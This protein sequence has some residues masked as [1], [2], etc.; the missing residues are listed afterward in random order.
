M[1]V[2]PA[3]KSVGA[4]GIGCGSQRRRFGVALVSNGPANQVPEAIGAQAAW[5]ALG[6]MR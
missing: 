2:M 4:V 6:R 1:V 5:P 3:R